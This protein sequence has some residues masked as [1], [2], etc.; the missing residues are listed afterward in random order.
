MSSFAVVCAIAVA[1][2]AVAAAADRLRRGSANS[3]PLSPVHGRYSQLSQQM[4][5]WTE[6]AA[7]AF[8]SLEAAD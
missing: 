4:N 5:L 7:A 8:V 1:A 2:S 3:L 6:I